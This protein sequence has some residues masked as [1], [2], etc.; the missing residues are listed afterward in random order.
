MMKLA[1][2]DA[3]DS[4]QTTSL[5]FNSAPWFGRGVSTGRGVT[6]RGT[7]LVASVGFEL[8][9]GTSTYNEEAPS[10]PVFKKRSTSIAWNMGGLSSTRTAV[11]TVGHTESQVET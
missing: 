3:A 4:T 7:G 6:T 11:E 5:R 9:A 1:G 2:E 10:A 8:A